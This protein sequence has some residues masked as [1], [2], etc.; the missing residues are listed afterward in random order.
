MPFI[1]ITVTGLDER[2]AR[3]N[4]IMGNLEQTKQG[5][6]EQVGEFMANQMRNNA[7]VITGYMKSTIQSQVLRDSVEVSVSAPYAAYENRRV[8]GP[9]APHDF[10]DRALSATLT[11][12]PQAMGQAYSDLFSRL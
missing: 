8:G 4:E 7:H 9:K 2:I 10:A 3:I 6:L 11:M 12:I 5:V 1:T